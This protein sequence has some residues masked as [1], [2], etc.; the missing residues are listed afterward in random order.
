MK[1]LKNRLAEKSKLFLFLRSNPSLETMSDILVKQEE[2]PDLKVVPAEN[3]DE[4]K[5]KTA[6][7]NAQIRAVLDKGVVTEKELSTIIKKILTKDK[8]T[9]ENK[10]SLAELNS[11]MNTLSDLMNTKPTKNEKARKVYKPFNGDYSSIK[12]VNAKN[13]SKKEGSEG[14]DNQITTEADHT[15]SSNKRDKAENNGTTD[16]IDGSDIDSIEGSSEEKWDPLE[17]IEMPATPLTKKG[18]YLY[19][20]LLKHFKK[21]TVNEIIARAKGAGFD[22]GYF[23]PGDTASIKS[24]KDGGYLIFQSKSGKERRVKIYNKRVLLDLPK[25]KSVNMEKTPATAKGGHLFGILRNQFGKDEAVRIIRLAEEYDGFDPHNYRPG[26]EFSMENGTLIKWRG[27]KEI[28]L[29]DIYGENEGDTAEKEISLKNESVANLSKYGKWIDKYANENGIEPSLLAGLIHRESSGVCTKISRKG[30]CGLTQVMGLAL[31]DVND[32]LGTSYKKS[33]L[34]DPEISI[35]VGAT[36]LG[37]MM[38]DFKDYGPDQTLLAL[39]AYNH[40]IG[41]VTKLAKRA[42]KE[43]R[44]VAELIS[45]I[46]FD[47]GKPKREAREYAMKVL[48]HAE[49]YKKLGYGPRR[50]IVAKRKK[51]RERLKKGPTRGLS[52][53]EAMSAL[54]SLGITVK[55]SGNDTRNRLNPK[56]TAVTGFMPETIKGLRILSSYVHGLVISGGTEVGHSGA[57][58]AAQMKRRLKNH[59]L[60]GTNTHGGG[61]KVDLPYSSKKTAK[62]MAKLSIPKTPVNAFYTK[63]VKGQKMKFHPEGNH[64]DITFYA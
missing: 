48:R 6:I 55:S 25:G 64:L 51:Q 57:K 14:G 40:G 32:R 62:L 2:N 61:R 37:M 3:D 60:E 1:T 56:A 28:E 16:V 39:T 53:E 36:Y 26:D 47:N 4:L 58:T 49:V 7:A 5:N 50:A 9:P 23:Q 30:A 24:E 54:K 42:K 38:N 20:I 34:T 41:K 46:N 31:K 45:E 59:T 8:S 21:P 13:F 44:P 27:G 22:V 12:N 63:V 43:G 18:G 15:T 52:Y 35:K 33:D 10:A 17:G 11:L 29:A 19:G